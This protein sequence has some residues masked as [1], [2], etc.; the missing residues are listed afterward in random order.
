MD[1]T[2]LGN[3]T[4]SYSDALSR[5]LIRSA[6]SNNQAQTKLKKETDATKTVDKLL[7]QLSSLLSQTLSAS[8]AE[9]ASTVLPGSAQVPGVNNGE[10]P[11]EEDITAGLLALLGLDKP[12]D[13]T[14]PLTPNEVKELIRQ[15]LTIQK[16]LQEIRSGIERLESGDGITEE[17]Q[18]ILD[19][20]K[21]GEEV[22]EQALEY[23]ERKIRNIGNRDWYVQ[24]R[25]MYVDIM[26]TKLN[27]RRDQKDI[28]LDARSLPTGVEA[29]D[30]QAALHDQ[31]GRPDLEHVSQILQVLSHRAGFELGHEEDEE[32]AELSQA[33]QAH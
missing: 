9:V 27:V 29:S 7:G 23:F 12:V 26:E 31:G 4:S 6:T 30:A 24:W 14:Q 13:E 25:L 10:R 18:A 3:Q 33:L 16:A 11:E 17:Q 28:K 2:R 8:D 20:L 22:A 1:F 15:Y 19:R 21:Q 5:S 32:L